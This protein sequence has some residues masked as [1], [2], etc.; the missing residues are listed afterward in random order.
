MQQKPTA[1]CSSIPSTAV[2]TTYNP[3]ACAPDRHHSRCIRPARGRVLGG[4]DRRIFPRRTA[5]DAAFGAR[6]FAEEFRARRGYNFGPLPALW[7]DYGEVSDRRFDYH[8]TGP[9]CVRKRSSSRWHKWHEDAACCAASTSKDPCVRATRSAAWK[10][11]PT[12]CELTAGFP[13]RGTDHHGHAKI[14]SSL[15]HLYGRPR[16]WIEA[17]HSSGGAA[18]EETFDWLVPWLPC[19][20][21]PVR[22]ARRLL[23]HPRRLGWEWAPPSTCWRQL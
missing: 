16:S 8:T 23:Q 14:H 21:Q 6:R 12:T 9:T 11:T 22:P 3:E 4:C 18:L 7:E 1:S 5:V 10:F 20:G 19:G 15:A 2:S 17:F 13:L